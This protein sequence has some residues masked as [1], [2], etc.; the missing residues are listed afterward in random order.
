MRAKTTTVLNCACDACGHGSHG[1]IEF[2]DGKIPVGTIN[3][4]PDSYKWVKMGVAVPDDEE[5]ELAAGMDEQAIQAAQHA[6]KRTALGIA[7]EDFEAYDRGEMTGYYRNG[8]PIP[9]PD[10]DVSDGGIILND[11]YEDEDDY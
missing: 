8:T 10:A 5:C 4:R 9:G 1:C 2:P 3:D 11:N 6:A 7:P